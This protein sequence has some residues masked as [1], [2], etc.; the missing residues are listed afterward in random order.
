[1]L[2]MADVVGEIDAIATLAA[3]HPDL[4]EACLRARAL[5]Q[6]LRDQFVLDLTGPAAPS[7]RAIERRAERPIDLDEE[8][9]ERRAPSG[10]GTMSSKIAAAR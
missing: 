1:M 7:A 6:R 3:G 5:P 2:A 4:A 9:S 10:G 8:R